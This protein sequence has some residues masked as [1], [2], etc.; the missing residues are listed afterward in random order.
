MY[1]L[2][3][4][5]KASCTHK[6]IKLNIPE[7]MCASKSTSPLRVFSSAFVNLHLWSINACHIITILH[8]QRVKRLWKLDSVRPRLKHLSS[9]WISQSTSTELVICITARDC[10]AEA[11]AHTEK[12]VHQYLVKN[13]RFWENSGTDFVASWHLQTNPGLNFSS[14]HLLA[15]GFY[16][17][18]QSTA[19]LLP[20]ATLGELQKCFSMISCET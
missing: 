18:I 9:L 4:W 15:K 10:P 11:V 16:S 1:S 19:T 12:I 8:L 7:S 14:L 13:W 6:L 20:S 2:L 5:S 3:K 17:F